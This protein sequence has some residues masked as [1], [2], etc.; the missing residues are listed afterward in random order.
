[1]NEEIDN[2]YN[3]IFRFSTAQNITSS[4]PNDLYNN[5][6]TA[7]GLSSLYNIHLPGDLPVINENHDNTS[8]IDID[9][10]KLLVS[11]LEKIMNNIPKL[12]P[13]PLFIPQ[14]DWHNNEKIEKEIQKL[15]GNQYMKNDDDNNNN[16][17]TAS[18]VNTNNQTPSQYHQGVTCVPYY[19]SYAN[20]HQWPPVINASPFL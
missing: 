6:V 15:L 5:E 9:Y 18:N 12:P 13:P 1:M 10:V 19:F 4:I 16:N 17:N 11:N 14:N 20:N 2:N 7:T 8:I 3:D